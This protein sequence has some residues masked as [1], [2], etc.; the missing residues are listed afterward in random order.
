MGKEWLL[1]RV[2]VSYVE[3]P[4]D[5]RIHF[6]GRP[7]P[8]KVGGAPR[9]FYQLPE[10]HGEQSHRPT[11]AIGSQDMVQVLRKIIPLRLVFPIGNTAIHFNMGSLEKMFLS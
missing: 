10:G 9:W 7:R 3:P 1:G 5:K 6:I 11:E 2:F 4:Q 8:E